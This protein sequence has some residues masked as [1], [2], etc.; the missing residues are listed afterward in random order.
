[1]TNPVIFGEETPPF[2]PC[3]IA[4]MYDD[5]CA[6]K[7]QELILKIFGVQD[8][9]ENI[10]RQE[11]YT[12]NWYFPGYGTPPDAVGNLLELHGIHVNMFEQA[13]QYTLMHELAQGHQVIVGVDSGELWNNGIIEI[14]EDIFGV[15]GADHALIVS[16][17]DASDP[18]NVQVVVTDP[19]MGQVRTYPFE[20][21]VNAWE[22]SS[23]FMVSTQMA[24]PTLDMPWDD[25]IMP[26]IMGLDIDDWL[27]KFGDMLDSGIDCASR[28]V[29]YFSDHPEILQAAE[30][31][32]PLFFAS[33][34]DLSIDSIGIESN[35]SDY[36]LG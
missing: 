12:L 35:D 3:D 29:D 25:G 30:G 11:A 15:S 5:T 2:A 31:I 6:I 14:V 7:S 9:D 8:I 19:G 17:I 10:L 1:M 4:Q 23:C 36:L 20:Q 34:E 28:I 13:N 16:G 18:N 21:F 24:P 22:D 27:H 33:S 32:A 26:Q